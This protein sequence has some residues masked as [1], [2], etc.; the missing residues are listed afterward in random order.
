M[1]CEGFE[2]L[3]GCHT[4]L[5]ITLATLFLIAVIFFILCILPYFFKLPTKKTKEIPR[6]DRGD[7]L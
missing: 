1:N 6:R 5:G 2:N 7:W 4:L 3:T